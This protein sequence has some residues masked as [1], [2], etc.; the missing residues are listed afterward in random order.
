MYAQST[1]LAIVGAVAL[2]L[3]TLELLRRR[4]LR[5]KYAAL[6]LA[7]SLGALF[8]ALLPELFSQVAR[9]LG[10]GLPVN[11][12]FFLGFVLLLVVSMQL[13]LEVGRREAETARLAEELAL[14]KRALLDAEARQIK[15][16]RRADHVEDGNK[17]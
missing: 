13:S 15:P 9:L 7:V 6:W 16:P 1:L 12:L 8:F 14:V 2:L 4:Q 17:G 3:L 5:E 10:F 11:L